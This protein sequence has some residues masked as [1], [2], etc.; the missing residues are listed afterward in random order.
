MAFRDHRRAI[1]ALI[2]DPENESKA[3]EVLRLAKA[4]PTIANAARSALRPAPRLLELDLAAEGYERNNLKMPERPKLVEVPDTLDE[5]LTLVQSAA[6][7][8]VQVRAIGDGWG[9][10]N[11]GFTKG[12]MLPMASK[13]REVLPLQRGVLRQGVDRDSLLFFEGGASIEDLNQHLFPRSRALLNQPG[14]EK[15]TFT[16]TMSSGGHGSGSWL[17]P[18]SSQVRALRL[19]TLDR[20]NR[21][22]QL[23]VEP[24][25]GISDRSKFTAANPKVELLQDDRMFHACTVAMGCLGIVSGAIIET[26]PGYNVL[27][28]RSLTT[29]DE[30]KPR[31]PQLIA[32]QG[33]GTRLH[34]IEVWV[35][36]YR[37]DGEIRCVLG[38][39]EETDDPPRNERSDAIAHGTPEFVLHA[40]SWFLRNFPSTVPAMMNA[41]LGLTTSSDVV[42]HAP[43]GLN[44]GATN[45]AP[46]LATSCGVPTAS[47]TTVVDDLLQ[48]FQQRR[49]SDHA[50]ISSPIGLRFV[51]AADAHM[52]PS[53]G[54]DTCMIEVPTLEGTPKARETLNAYLDFLF[55]KHQGR[56][57]WGQVNDT[58]GDRLASLYP[59]LDA[60]LESYRVLN[61]KGFFDNAFTEQMGLRMRA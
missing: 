36:P 44:F 20:T 27:E 39:R 53:F 13:L 60:F 61:P 41:A 23:Q 12:F 48:F 4:E 9:F 29:W 11:T 43:E 7:Q 45:S 26:R 32:D 21:V 50:Y 37:C 1:Q 16:G 57:H 14:F 6:D 40:T 33:P 24:Q 30:L 59:N 58:P 42:M 3:S 56:P 22:T 55:T 8:F 34:S 54:R 52:S 38:E 46:V 17:G 18:L 28:N 2:D 51:K 31:L 47:I 25:D 10:S 49:A 5:L 19:V 15:L 35:N